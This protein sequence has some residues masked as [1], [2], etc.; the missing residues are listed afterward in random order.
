MIVKFETER[1]GCKMFDGFE[2]VEW[3]YE[4][5]CP[6]RNVNVVKVPGNVLKT[7]NYQYINGMTPDD[8]VRYATVA[9]SV[10]ADDSGFSMVSVDEI[11]AK[12]EPKTADDSTRRA[13]FHCFGR[14]GK[15][16]LFYSELPV[17]ILNDNGKTVERV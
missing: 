1:C 12:D 15:L 9:N 13:L 5:N 16:R 7:T 14:D 10:S 3:T 11:F 8:M 17:Y 4:V 6:D 2:S